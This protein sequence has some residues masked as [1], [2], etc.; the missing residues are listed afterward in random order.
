MNFATYSSH[1]PYRISR[2]GAAAD[3]EGD[4]I[5]LFHFK[6]INNEGDYTIEQLFSVKKKKSLVLECMPSS[7][8]IL[9]IVEESI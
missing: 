4:A 9:L 7:A 5:F 8:F 2:T 1:T 6:K 3:S